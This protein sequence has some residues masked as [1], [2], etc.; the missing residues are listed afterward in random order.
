MT[1][2]R[3]RLDAVA[4]TYRVPADR[5]FTD[6][7]Q[8]LAAGLDA[9]FVH[10]PTNQHLPV[11]GRLL[12]AGVPVYVDK[13]L[14]NTLA[15]ARQLVDQAER[16]DVLLRVGFNRRHVPAYEQARERPRDLISVW[17]NEI[18]ST[19]PVRE[20]VF[21]DF[22]HVVDTLRFL[23]PGPVER[24]VVSGRVAAGDLHHV[25]LTLSGPGFTAVGSMHR[26]S[27]AKEER[28]EVTGDGAKLAVLDLDQVVVHQ[29]GTRT[30]RP[31]DGWSPVA[32]RRGFEQVCTAF[33]D[34]V[35]A[36]APDP[37]GLADALLTHELCEQVVQ[38]LEAR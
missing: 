26:L 22:I 28:L 29:A 6:I 32:R 14:D 10:V 31:A 11:V 37:V 17:K 27:G 36:G 2:S 24:T 23:L 15:G 5:L 4:G 34:A 8:L 13:P 12:T 19:G 7:E 3:E 20:I 16:A 1:R 38:Q 35:R 33:V 9:A 30:L 25:S 21:D 18:D